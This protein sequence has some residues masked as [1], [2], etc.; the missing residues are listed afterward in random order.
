MRKKR[1]GWEW[2]WG[3][4]GIMSGLWAMWG[5]EFYSERD[6]SHPRAQ[7][8]ES[9]HLTQIKMMG[10]EFVFWIN[11]RRSMMKCI[12]HFCCYLYVLLSIY[13]GI[14][15]C[16]CIYIILCIYIFFHPTKEYLRLL[17]LQLCWL[18]IFWPLLILFCFLDGL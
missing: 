9:P 10:Q 6:G 17:L 7:A 2:C 11:Y 12:L 15:I 13:L 3:Y 14:C 5:L 16:V 1:E 8:E 18:L 4:V